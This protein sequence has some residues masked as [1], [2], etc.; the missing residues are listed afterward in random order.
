MPQMSANLVPFL[1]LVV[2][3]ES[4]TC[5]FRK[6]NKTKFLGFPVLDT[7]R[8]LVVNLF[9]KVNYFSLLPTGDGNFAVVRKCRSRKTKADFALKIIDKSKCMYL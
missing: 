8:H 9:M 5:S 3:P 1:A 6:V 4:S 7:V 2:H